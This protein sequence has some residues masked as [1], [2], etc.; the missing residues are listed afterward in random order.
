VK[1]LA[2]DQQRRW[3]ELSEALQS[4]ARVCHRASRLGP[5]DLAWLE[6]HFLHHIF[7]VL[8]PTAVDPAHPFPFIP[9]LGF[10]L[11]LQ[12][13]RQKDGRVL[14][15]LIRLPPKVDRL[16]CLPSTPAAPGLRFVP[17]EQVILLSQPGCSRATWFAG[18]GAFPRHT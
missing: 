17:L 12:L 3:C 6:N 2:A 1:L 16:V 7:P 4:E 9:N 5:E 15:A 13:M 11:A 14:R 18:H 10:S 8:T